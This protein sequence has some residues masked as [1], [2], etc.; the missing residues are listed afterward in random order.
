MRVLAMQ[1]SK[2]TPLFNEK[3]YLSCYIV[4]Y[5]YICCSRTITVQLSL[6]RNVFFF[7]K[8]MLKLSIDVQL[9][10]L[11]LELVSRT[12]V[13]SSGLHTHRHHRPGWDS[14][15]QCREDSLH[16]PCIP[17]TYS[18]RCCTLDCRD[19]LSH[20]RTNTDIKS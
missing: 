19:S 7:Y 18:A 11:H 8:L 6:S 16:Y 12:Q 1:S 20:P 5:H 4:I 9:F 2:S 14:R 17:C 10:Q 3:L 15:Q 13:Y